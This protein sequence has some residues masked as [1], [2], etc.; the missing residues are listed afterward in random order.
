M[1]EDTGPDVETEGKNLR[2]PVIIEQDTLQIKSAESTHLKDDVHTQCDTADVTLK[3]REKSASDD[4]GMEDTDWAKFKMEF[5]ERLQNSEN[6]LK[7]EQSHED[8]VTSPSSNLRQQLLINAIASL[9]SSR[10]VQQ[11]DEEQQSD[12]NKDQTSLQFSA[13]SEN[14]GSNIRSLVASG[15]D[16]RVNRDSES[17][18]EHRQAMVSVSNH[19]ESSTDA[20][21]S[22]ADSNKIAGERE[23]LMSS[24]PSQKSLLSLEAF[25]SIHEASLDHA[26]M[27]IDD[28]RSN[29]ARTSGK[30]HGLDLSNNKGPP[31]PP[32]EPKLAWGAPQ[33]GGNESLMKELEQLSLTQGSS[34]ITSSASSKHRASGYSKGMALYNNIVIH[35]VYMYI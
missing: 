20:A 10:Q 19:A 30:D 2:A 14:D 23:G 1:E 33:D 8:H 35:F 31:P 29:I 13:Q 7:S 16:I 12:E 22:T 15:D 34:K 27:N 9:H 17:I 4:S 21:R 32:A 28:T 5:S 11:R 25:D 26:L 6:K 24:P 18:S 3:S